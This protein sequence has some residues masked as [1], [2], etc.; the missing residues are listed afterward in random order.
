M[1]GRV[2]LVPAAD[3]FPDELSGSEHQLGCVVRAVLRRP[4]LLVADE[5]GEGLR[6]AAAAAARELLEEAVV[7]GACL[8]MASTVSDPAS[9]RATFVIRLAPPGAR[10]A[11]EGSGAPG[12]TQRADIQAPDADE[13]GAPAGNEGRGT[14][15]REAPG[16]NDR[17][18]PGADDEAD[19]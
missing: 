12:A 10:A 13:R 2:D 8:V 4:R 9:P 7:Q 19:G 16:A 17:E 18:A 3:R 6:P 1:L 5:P 14:P 11:I 15:G